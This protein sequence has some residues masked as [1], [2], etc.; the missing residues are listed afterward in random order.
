[1][2]VPGWSRRPARYERLLVKFG[3]TAKANRQVCPTDPSVNLDQG[4][5][6]RGPKRHAGRVRSRRGNPTRCERDVHGRV[7]ITE[8][9]HFTEITEITH[10]KNYFSCSLKTLVEA[11]VPAKNS[12]APD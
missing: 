2:L 3:M 1:M 12:N 7:N 11:L 6:A 10:E 5:W 4:F 8:I 9:T